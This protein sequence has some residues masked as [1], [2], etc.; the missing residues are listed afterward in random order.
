MGTNY[1][2]YFKKE[3]I[4]IGKRCAAGYYCHECGMSEANISDYSPIDKYGTDAVHLIDHINYNINENMRGRFPRI[5]RKCPICNKQFTEKTCSFS[6]A[7]SPHRLGIIL[8]EFEY[9]IKDEYGDY[10]DK[11][12]FKTILKNC[13]IKYYHGVGVDF[14]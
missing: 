8:N 5:L 14:S 10:I 11:Q 6:F 13:K 4:H 1:Y 12:D 3:I 2:A 9:T 7:V